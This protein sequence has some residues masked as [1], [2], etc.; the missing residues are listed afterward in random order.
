MFKEAAEGNDSDVQM[1]DVGKF[2]SDRPSSLLHPGYEDGNSRQYSDRKEGA[3]HRDMNSQ[4]EQTPSQPNENSGVEHH[5]KVNCC[6][7]D[8]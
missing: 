2:S 4:E 3:E 1:E 6:L 5:Q 8:C 7:P